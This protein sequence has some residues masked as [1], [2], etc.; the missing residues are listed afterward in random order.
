M[1]AAPIDLPIAD[2]RGGLPPGWRRVVPAP[3]S[4]VVIAP[5]AGFAQ[6]PDAAPWEVSVPG[7]YAR[8]WDWVAAKPVTPE[9]DP[10]TG[11]V[12][13]ET[14]GVVL[15]LTTPTPDGG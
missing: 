13:L 7:Q 4:S 5:G 12:W 10:L 9:H 8:C 6:H 14:G 3:G 1:S 15:V 2:P 11:R